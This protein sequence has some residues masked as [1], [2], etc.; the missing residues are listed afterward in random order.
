[1]EKKMYYIIDNGDTPVTCDLNGLTA[2]LEAEA[3]SYNED[4]NKEDKPQWDIT[5]VWLTE[6]EFDNLPEA[7]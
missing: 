6:D 7:Y 5:L 3:T 1:M 4:S 2:M